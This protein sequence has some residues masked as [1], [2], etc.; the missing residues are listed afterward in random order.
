MGWLRRHAAGLAVA[1]V[2]ALLAANFVFTANYVNSTQAAQQRAAQ[3]AQ[4]A[5]RRAGV[6]VEHKICTTLG[7]LAA[8]QPPPGDPAA[9]P[10]RLYEQQQHATLSQ[11]GPDLGCGKETSR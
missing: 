8:L 5:Q 9:N 3:A 10:A 11:L 6:A 1:A 2:L 4:D 7:E